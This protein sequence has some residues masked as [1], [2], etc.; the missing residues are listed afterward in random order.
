MLYAF[1]EI[2]LVMVGILL[3]LQVNNWNESV[4]ERMRAKEILVDLQIS[5]EVNRDEL[6]KNY[7]RVQQYIASTDTILLAM[8]LKQELSGK[9]RSS[10][11]QTLYT[12]YRLE[13]RLSMSGYPAFES[14]S[15][16]VFHSKELAIAVIDLYE[17]HFPW[18]ESRGEH[19]SN[20]LKD[21]TIELMK[22]G[23]VTYEEDET[24]L[25]ADIYNPD[26]FLFL[27]SII[28]LRQSQKKRGQSRLQEGIDKCTLVLSL[29]E[30]EL[31]E[32]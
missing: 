22:I 28:S 11:S 3:A 14:L 26:S 6:E 21:I 10:F 2:L 16:D 12:G 31:N 7:V 15:N 19:W 4:Q 18:L 20:Y 8:D 17:T 30:T 24:Y 5:T 1:G 9:L 23:A 29:I 27:R 25:P 32:Y 13:D